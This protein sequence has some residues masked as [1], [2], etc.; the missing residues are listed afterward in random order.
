[1]MTQ[2]GALLDRISWPMAVIMAMFLGLAPF[3]PEPHIWEK[4]KLLGAGELTHALDM[5]DLA[6]HGLPWLVLGGKVIRRFVS[7]RPAG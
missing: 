2:L 1:M 4:L 7:E 3:T 6:F 5:F